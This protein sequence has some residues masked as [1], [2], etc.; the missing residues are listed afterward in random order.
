[1]SLYTPRHFASDQ[2]SDALAL[3]MANPF[4]TLI[5]TVV[6]AAPHISHL[7]LLLENGQLTGH[8]ARAN[9]HWQTFAR[10]HTVAVFH[11]PHTYISPRWYAQ[12]EREVPTWNYATVHIHGQPV[13]VD[14]R[15]AKLAIVDRTTATFEPAVNPWQRSVAGPRLEAML[16]NI[17]G[18][19]LPLTQ[20]QAK[21]K[22]S[23]NRTP[24]DRALV[25]AQLR[26]QPHP[27]HAAMADW[28]QD[29]E[30]R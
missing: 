30:P 4:A 21:F 7:P 27:D 20:V 10:G 23:Q 12:P 1:M 13:L 14:E 3:I 26:A 2:P 28:M 9:P 8:M 24:E 16:A 18:F 11:G 19:Y 17:I 5:T 22:L 25:I 6:D 15:D 29:H